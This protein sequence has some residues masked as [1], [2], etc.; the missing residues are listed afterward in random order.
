MDIFKSK[1][2]KKFDND[3]DAELLDMEQQTAASNEV[4]I[5]KLQ[6]FEEPDTL[7]L[8][9]RFQHA[10]DCLAQPNIYHRTDVKSFVRGEIKS[11][12]PRFHRDDI[13]RVAHQHLTKQ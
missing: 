8:V 5:K 4:L 6:E 2:V 7:E 10:L 1:K 11:L 13:I 3:L 9:R 12:M